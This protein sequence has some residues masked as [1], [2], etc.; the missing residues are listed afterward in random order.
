VMGMC[1][2][3]QELQLQQPRYKHK[4]K[5]H[6]LPSQGAKANWE[7]GVARSWE[8]RPLGPGRLDPTAD[9]SAQWHRN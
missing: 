3:R 2:K 5:N 8:A 9:P 1:A 7:L 4:W 6:L